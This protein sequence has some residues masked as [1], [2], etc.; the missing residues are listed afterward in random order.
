M[1]PKVSLVVPC[2]NGSQF[3]DNFMKSIFDLKYDN[4]QLIIT[5]DGS[6][7]D[8]YHKIK[9]YES[10][11]TKKGIEFLLLHKENGGQPSAFNCGVKY[12][13][14]KYVAWP[15]I[16]DRMHP[17]FIKR[18]VEYMEAHPDIDF[19]LSRSAIVPLNNPT[20]VLGYTWPEKITDNKVLVDRTLRGYRSWFEPG[21]YFARLDSMDSF[22]KDRHIY[23]ESGSWTGAQF[24]IV[25]PFFYKGRIGYVDECLYDYYI[26]D[27]QHHI[28]VKD[29]DKLIRKNIEIKKVL[30]ATIKNLNSPNE[31]EMLKIIEERMVRSE[32]IQAFGLRDKEWFFEV[33]CKMGPQ[34]LTK[35]DKMRYFMMKNSFFYFFYELYK[36]I[37]TNHLA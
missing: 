30:T 16:D 24:Q 10:E 29:K 11:I 9:A 13:T 21:A 14:G 25:L 28:L 22:L 17:N 1:N 4:I 19:L 18:K 23:E 5:D 3:I 12:A 36:K 35:K 37:H 15:D 27:R 6:T 31:E 20:K 26:H 8:S 33:Y 7:D 34:M 2:Y 32:M